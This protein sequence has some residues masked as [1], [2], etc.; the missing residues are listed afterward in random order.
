M[1]GSW[2][3][4]CKGCSST[5]CTCGGDK[6]KWGDSSLLGRRLSEDSD[7]HQLLQKWASIWTSLSGDPS[8]AC[9]ERTRREEAVEPA[10]EEDR[11]LVFLCSGCRRP[12]G[13]SL[14]WVTSQEDTNCIL[15]RCVSCNVSVDKEQ[16][17]S[18]RKN[19]NGCVLETLYCSGCSLNLGHI[20]R[21]TPKSLDYKRDL[22]CLRVEAIESYI[23]GSSEKQI[24]SEDKELFNLES[25]VEIEK[26]L[27]QMEDV[28][29]ALQA[30]LWEVESKLSFTSC[31][32]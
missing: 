23:L 22:F 13:D 31:K 7:R 20:Y 26:S 8:V 17:L 11:P 9:A 15:L 6:G 1:A 29:K 5:S 2:S 4:G 18:K 24:V 14:S 19:E 12:L 32:S 25:R 30:K 28:L 16:I 3:P 21:C 10:E 27:K